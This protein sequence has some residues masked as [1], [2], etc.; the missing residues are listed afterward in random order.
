MRIAIFT[1]VFLPKIDGIT[2]RLRHTVECLTRDGHEVLVFAPESAVSEHAGA[3]VI[4]VV[5]L[6][7]PLYPGLRVSFPD[8]RIARELL[9]FRPHVV[10]AVGPACLGVWGMAA[11]RAL[12]LPLVASYHT[13]LPRY[14]SRYGLGLAEP[15]VWRLL[16]D[17]HNGATLNLC[18]SRFTREELISRG[19]RDVEAYRKT[20]A[21]HYQRRSLLRGLRRAILG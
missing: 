4:T 11:A 8:P 1:E 2:N 5:G 12:D 14:A 7:F 21:L 15:L 10:H 18:P 16:R 9:R 3:R 13:D 19:V 20:L 17:V 6:P